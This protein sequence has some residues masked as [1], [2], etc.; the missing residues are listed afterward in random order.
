MLAN[1]YHKGRF[2]GGD[3]NQPGEMLAEIRLFLERCT[4]RPLWSGA[5]KRCR[6]FPIS[7]PGRFGTA[8]CS[9]PHG[10]SGAA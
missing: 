5:M 9:Y 4:R 8:T 1:H 10:P 6:C 2:A 7:I 3:R